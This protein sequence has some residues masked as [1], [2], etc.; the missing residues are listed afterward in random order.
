MAQIG[1]AKIS[2]DICVVYV[3]HNNCGACGEVCPTHAIR[4]IDKN[5]IRYPKVDA[6][7]CIGCGACQLV[8]P[9]PPKA[10]VV[11][12]NQIHQK[13]VKY[14]HRRRKQSSWP[15]TVQNFPF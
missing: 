6:E 14:R 1:I 5:N 10:I 12:P 15:D 11:G 4:F 7:Y 8:C 9:T 3:D 13:A 2:E